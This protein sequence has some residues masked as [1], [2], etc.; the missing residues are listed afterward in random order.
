[1][2]T[3]TPGKLMGVLKEN[4]AQLLTRISAIFSA[5]SPPPRALTSWGAPGAGAGGSRLWFVDVALP[6]FRFTSWGGC[7]ISASHFTIPVDSKLLSCLHCRLLLALGFWDVGLRGFSDEK[8]L[9]QNRGKIASKGLVVA[10]G[11]SKTVICEK[12]LC[13]ATGVTRVL[14]MSR[15]LLYS[16]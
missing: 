2:A 1:M 8:G 14:D 15:E 7:Q 6:Y 5:S 3:L 4:N 12:W 9:F 13:E 16:K 11:V 10:T